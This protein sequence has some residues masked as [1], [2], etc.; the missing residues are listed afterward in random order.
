MQTF[1]TGV[2]AQRGFVLGNM[3]VETDVGIAYANI[4]AHASFLTKPIND[5]IFHFVGDKA[6][7]AEFL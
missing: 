4:R 6:G 2:K 1:A 7:I 3:D 5:G